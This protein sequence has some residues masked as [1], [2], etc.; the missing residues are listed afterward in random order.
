MSADQ[1][2]PYTPAPV[3]Q[4]DGSPLANSNCRMASI[5]TGLDYETGGAKRST[6]AAMRSHTSDQSGGTDS[7]DAAQAWR[8]GYG[9]TLTVRD[10][11]TWAEALAELVAGHL[12]HLDVW[13]ATVGGPCLSGS[14]SYG[15][16]MA[17]LPDCSS[18]SWLVADPWCS[19]GRWSRV[20]EGKL[21]A[22]AEQWG[23]EVYGRA[24]EEPDYPTGGPGP[25]DPAVLLIVR[26]VA[27]ALMG[28]YHAGGEELVPRFTAETGGGQ[29]ILYTETHERSEDMGDVT[30]RDPEAKLL[31][32]SAG[33]EVLNLDGS[34]RTSVKPERAG[35]YTSPFGSTTAG[36]TRTRAIVWTRADPDPDL[37]L[38][39]YENDAHNL[40]PACEDAG[41]GDPDAI[42]AERDAE[43]TDWLLAG[44]P[45]EAG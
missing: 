22:G 17:V 3:T 4:R 20:A 38:A 16:T 40:R 43:W 8:E 33:A 44:S 37:L 28:R 42:K 30:V 45:G 1:R 32:L 5:A 41:G 25:R 36:G 26:R 11:R 24:R 13:H 14:G 10:G 29:P 2:A 9:E 19:P 27:R 39:C 12:V 15:H 31:E 35:T 7:G 6:G 21:R 18:G 23:A 34:A